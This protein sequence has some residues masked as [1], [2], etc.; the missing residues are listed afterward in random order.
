MPRK[1]RPKTP[2]IGDMQ[3]SLGEFL[4]SELSQRN[5]RYGEFAKKFARFGRMETEASIR[6][7][8]ARGKFSAV[9]LL[10]SLQILRRDRI[11]LRSIMEAGKRAAGTGRENASK[12]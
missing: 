11:D 4:K 7:K 10:L 5:M 6:N 1:V 9:F 2:V 3:Y 12:T 8:L